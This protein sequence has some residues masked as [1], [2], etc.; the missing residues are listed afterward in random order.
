MFSCKHAQ[1]TRVTISLVQSF[2][3][4]VTSWLSRFQPFCLPKIKK[5]KTVWFSMKAVIAGTKIMKKYWKLKMCLFIFSVLKKILK[6]I[7]SWKSMKNRWRKHR[8]ILTLNCK[9][10]ISTIR[11][12]FWFHCYIYYCIRILKVLGFEYLPLA[13]G[14]N[15]SLIVITNN[16]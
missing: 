9:P 6:S 10:L 16:V 7:E 8:K 3:L 13:V 14:G 4:T 15:I 12:K 5:L 11:L 1:K 2:Q